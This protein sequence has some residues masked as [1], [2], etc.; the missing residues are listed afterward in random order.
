MQTVAAP[1]PCLLD[2]DVLFEVFDKLNL[3]SL[4]IADP[5]CRTWHQYMLPDSAADAKQSGD[6]PGNDATLQDKVRQRYHFAGPQ[7]FPSPGW[8]SR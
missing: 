5:V 6:Q 1:H 8:R 3:R 2:S 7:R 4:L